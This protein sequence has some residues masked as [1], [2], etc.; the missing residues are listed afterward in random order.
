MA[1]LGPALCH[2]P[3]GEEGEEVRS[4]FKVSS[5]AEGLVVVAQ[6]EGL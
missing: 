3:T 5:T 1:L 4:G 2:K 6:G